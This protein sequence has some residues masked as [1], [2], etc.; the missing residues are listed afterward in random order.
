MFLAAC[1][2]VAAPGKGKIFYASVGI[3]PFMRRLPKAFSF[4]LLQHFSALALLGISI[5]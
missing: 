4:W 3:F 1:H 5:T 2:A